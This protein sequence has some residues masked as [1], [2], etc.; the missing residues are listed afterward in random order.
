M[1]VCDFEFDGDGGFVFRELPIELGAVALLVYDKGPG[2]NEVRG[3]AT[4][5]DVFTQ[6]FLQGEHGTV[7]EI[8][9]DLGSGFVVL[10]LLFAVIIALDVAITVFS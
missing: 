10:L 8:S 6:L 2:D 9:L 3:L 5:V 1:G 4:I 7:V